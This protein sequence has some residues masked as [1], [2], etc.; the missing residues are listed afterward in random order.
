[1][2]LLQRRIARGHAEPFQHGGGQRF[3]NAAAQLAEKREE[4]AAQPAR[5][6]L[7]AAEGL[8]DGRDAAHLQAGELF[9]RLGQDF[10]LRLDHFEAA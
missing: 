9:G 4:L 7:G 10:K 8:V 2:H 6:E 5:A 3:R 1:M